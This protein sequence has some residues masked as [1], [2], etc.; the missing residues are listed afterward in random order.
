[1]K[2]LFN[3]NVDHVLCMCLLFQSKILLI[4]HPKLYPEVLII[5]AKHM[6]VKSLWDLVLMNLNCTCIV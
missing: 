5:M 6:D 4:E 2:A 1:M 3:Y